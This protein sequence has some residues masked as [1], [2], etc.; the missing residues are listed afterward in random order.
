MKFAP[1][2]A[3]DL[4]ELVSVED[5]LD[6]FEI[7][8]DPQIAQVNRLHILQR[9]HDYLNTE[10]THLAPDSASQRT[11]YHACLERAYQDFVHSCALNEKVFRVFHHGKCGGCSQSCNT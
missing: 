6:F 8:Y 9:F 2:F 7:E 10:T 1:D 4:Q 3:A 11:F 5:F